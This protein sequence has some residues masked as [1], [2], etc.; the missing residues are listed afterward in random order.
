MNIISI[1]FIILLIITIGL[2]TINLISTD[3]SNKGSLITGDNT[4]KIPGKIPKIIPFIFPIIF[5]DIT[6]PSITTSTTPP[7]TPRVLT[8]VNFGPIQ[9]NG[10]FCSTPGCRRAL[11][12][13]TGITTMDLFKI[14]ETGMLMDFSFTAGYQINSEESIQNPFYIEIINDIGESIYNSEYYFGNVRAGTT[15][16]NIT[17][18]IEVNKNDKVRIIVISHFDGNYTKIINPVINLTIGI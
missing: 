6:T 2:G 8:P 11:N 18:N 7:T 4:G 12:T 3:S 16:F 1:L 17:P 5:P 10:V 15:N 9:I 13:D 14:P